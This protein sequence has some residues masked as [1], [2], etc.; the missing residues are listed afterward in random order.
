MRVAKS[1]DNHPPGS[2]VVVIRVVSKTSKLSTGCGLLIALLMIAPGGVAQANAVGEAGGQ[3]AAEAASSYHAD[4]SG[5]EEAANEQQ[6]DA[7]EQAADEVRNSGDA[8]Q[9]AY[10][11][12]SA[13]TKTDVDRPACETCRDAAST[14]EQEGSGQFA[15]AHEA[16]QAA[17]VENAY[18][19]AGADA[20]AA[21]EAQAWYNQLFDGVGDAMD[22]LTGV[23]DQ[24]TQ[25][26]EQVDAKAEQ[27]MDTE[28]QARDEVA[29]TVESEQN[30]SA[31]VEPSAEGGASG[32]HATSAATSTVTEAGSP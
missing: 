3:A 29:S 18:V 4:A 24:D 7:R 2:G 6:Q 17:D 1:L 20:Q 11:E 30:V 31:P 14:V 8:Y 16:E 10:A 19:D 22:K 32:E 26:H 27:S 5:A 28:T 13:E 12:A 9:D 21:G 15:T 23:L 25:A